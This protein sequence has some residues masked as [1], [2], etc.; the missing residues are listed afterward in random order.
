VRARL[1]GLA[2]DHPRLALGLA[3]LLILV[4]LVGLSRFREEEDILTFLPASEPDV[5][6]FRKVASDFGALRVALIGVEPKGGQPL[7]SAEVLGRLERLSTGLRSIGGVERV[8]SLSTMTDLDPQEGSVD[9]R[10]L[11][12]SPLPTDAAALARLRDRALS[13]PQVRGTIVSADGQAALVLVFLTATANT[14]LVAIRAQELARAEMGDATLY[15]G[16]APFAGQAIYD[17]TQVDVR[18]LTPLAMVL[19]FG[20]VLL[21]FRD[22]L[23]VVLTVGTVGVA[24]IVVVGGMGLFGEPFTVVTAMLP[25][26]L[27][28]AGS[29][30]AIHI[31]GR[32]YLLRTGQPAREAAQGALRIAG[33]P[34]TIA[35]AATSLGFL[36]FLVM[37]IRPMRSFGIACACGIF[38]CWLLSLTVLPAVVAAWPRPY[39]KH[40]QLLA[41]EDLLERLWTWVQG[42]RWLIVA[43]GVIL[44]AVSAGYASQVQVRMEPRA[45]FRPGSEPARAQAFLDARF[46]GS[47]FLQVA[48]SGDVLHPQ[49]LRELR[50][51]CDYA[52]SL[53]GVT[54]VQSILD[55]LQMV[56]DAMGTGGALPARRKQVGNLLFFIEG[57]PSIKTLLSKDGGGALLHVRVSGDPRPVLRDLEAYLKRRWPYRGTGHSLD[58]L[59]E[60]AGWLLQGG[61]VAAPTEGIDTTLA[62]AAATTADPGAVLP[63]AGREALYR[64]ALTQVLASPEGA[65]LTPGQREALRKRGA[66]PQVLALITKGDAESLAQAAGLLA[67]TGAGAGQAGQ[68]AQKPEPSAEVEVA[69]GVLADRYASGL[70][71]RAIAAWVERLKDQGKGAGQAPENKAHDK[72][73]DQDRDDALGRVVAAVLTP[74]AADEGAP[75]RPLLGAIS[76]EPVLDRGFSNAVEQNQWA[77]LRVALVAVFLVLLFSL[78]SVGA[79]ILCMIP[80]GLSLSVVFGLLGATGRPIDIGTSLVGSIVTGSG[81]DFA[82]HYM[83][84]LRRNHPREVARNVG[85]VILITAVLLGAGLGVLGLGQSPPLQLFGWLGAGGMVMSGI[86][87]FLLVPALLRKT[88]AEGRDFG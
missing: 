50:R 19:F 80:A 12:P 87:T 32:Y 39:E 22:W 77:S 78:R 23:A 82:M 4:S 6:T 69:L 17:D 49:A 25:V 64:D 29:Q 24:G 66:E 37:N 15:F 26:I 85:P 36:S 65:S 58:E 61:Q 8:V 18:R 2:L 33:P 10:P 54:Q 20:V 31:L 1:P 51:L 48:V 84:Y 47:Q 83:W 79:A 41:L 43:G 76:G 52:R 45:F 35:G 30:Y 13:L 71:A 73:H 56:G 27:F 68:R 16:G 5:V 81:A 34:V 21:S 14:R 59:A 44:L 62:A 60:E 88:R 74:V 38:V 86:F 3:G 42:R 55:P 9:V 7:F 46:G 40:R 75:E 57:E 11:L 67:E 63:Q 72:A 70:R 53:P 28:A